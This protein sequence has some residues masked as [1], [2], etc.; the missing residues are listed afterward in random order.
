MKVSF[1][2]FLIY[3]ESIIICAVVFWHD[4]AANTVKCWAELL[5]LM[6]MFAVCLSFHCNS[7]IKYVKF[8]NLSL[9]WAQICIF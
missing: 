6:N 8:L 3:I 1:C 7:Y 2:L 9:R 4:W 5:I